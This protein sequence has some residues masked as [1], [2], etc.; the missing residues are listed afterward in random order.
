[1]STRWPEEAERSVLA[2]ILAAACVDVELGHRVLRRA[3]ATGLH[4]A[5]FWL[6]SHGR[7]FEALIRLEQ[8]GQPLDPV[9]LAAELDR[10]HA[11]PTIVSRLRVLAHEHAPSAAVARYSEIVRDAAE[12]REIA[13]RA[14]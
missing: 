5:H 13:E 12:A 14:A 8:A 3:R 6:A 10:D 4:P 1:M 7:L 2:A 9:S 11:D